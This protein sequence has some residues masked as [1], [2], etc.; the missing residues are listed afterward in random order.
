LI[1]IIWAPVPRILVGEFDKTGHDS[2]PTLDRVDRQAP[3]EHLGS[4]PIDHRVEHRL[5]SSKQRN[6][7]ATKNMWNE[8]G[9]LISHVGGH[10]KSG[11]RA[12]SGPLLT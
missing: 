4:P 9:K 2:T 8:P 10:P 7:I 6:V 5:V 1:D 3:C 12:P 11:Q